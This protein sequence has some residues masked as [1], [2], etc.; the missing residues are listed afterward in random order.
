MKTCRI[1][2]ALTQV[3]PNMLDPHLA[4][5]SVLILNKKMFLLCLVLLMA[6]FGC[7]HGNISVGA[8]IICF[9]GTTWPH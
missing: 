2:L 7:K 9:Y 5:R 4:L 6:F 1:S 3:G 8:F